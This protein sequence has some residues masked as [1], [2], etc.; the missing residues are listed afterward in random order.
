LA[1]DGHDLRT[2]LPFELLVRGTQGQIGSSP[3]Q[4]DDGFRLGQIHFSVKEGAFR[5]FPGLG[6]AG[7]CPKTGFEDLRGD[8]DPAVATNLHQILAGITCRRAMH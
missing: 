7:A 1:A 3:D 5:E 2:K 4:I 8:K 6:G